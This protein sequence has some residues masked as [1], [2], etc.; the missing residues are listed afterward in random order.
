MAGP[1]RVAD[2]LSKATPEAARRVIAREAALAAALFGL[3]LAWPR[4]AARAWYGVIVIAREAIRSGDSGMLLV[5][6]TYGSAQLALA[7][8][9]LYLALALGGDAASRALALG[10]P[11]YRATRASL[12]AAGPALGRLGLAA[13]CW[14]GLAAQSALSVQPWEP[15]PAALAL[16]VTQSEAMT[17]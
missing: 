12:G 2:P 1:S 9:A 7:A 16:A 17:A 14:L 11:S 8:T 10:S 6:S 4:I 3:W 5:A 13:L 15:L